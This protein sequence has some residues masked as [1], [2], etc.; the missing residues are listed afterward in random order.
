MLWLWC[1]NALEVFYSDSW[2]ASGC[3]CCPLSLPV[4]CN[5]CCLKKGVASYYHGIT[6]G[7]GQ[8]VEGEGRSPEITLL[9]A[10]ERQTVEGKGRSP[11]EVTLLTAGQGQTDEGKGR[12]PEITLLTA[13]ER[14][15]VVEL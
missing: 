3:C 9:T 2:T 4:R 1:R 8:T 5:A 10:G 15:T 6:A 13:G 12:S 11:S 14:Q 7:A